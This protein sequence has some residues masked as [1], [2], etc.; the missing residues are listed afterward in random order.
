MV[1]A[2][3]AARPA[4]TGKRQSIGA[5]PQVSE[6]ARGGL[7]VAIALRHLHGDPGV[8]LE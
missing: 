1:A 7:C 2:W 4:R 6:V 5:S 3:P 8:N